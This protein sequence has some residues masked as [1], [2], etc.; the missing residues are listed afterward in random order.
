M[1]SN[2]TTSETIIHTAEPTTK[3]RRARISSLLSRKEREPRAACPGAMNP[4]GGESEPNLRAALGGERALINH[5]EQEGGTA[6]D[7]AKPLARERTY[8]WCAISIPDAT[9]RRRRRRFDIRTCWPTRIF[10][11]AMLILWRGT[12]FVVTVGG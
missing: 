10:E 9:C 11:R 2:L 5:R 4:T 1:H 7:Y 3:I 6:R 12:V 8:A